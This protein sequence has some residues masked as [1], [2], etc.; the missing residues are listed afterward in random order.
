MENQ[1]ENTC[2]APDQP[3]YEGEI[4][5]LIRS[6]SS[7]TVLKEKLED[8]HENDIADALPKL[9][10][11]ERKKIYRMLSPE[12]LA[13]ILEYAEDS[14]AALYL[15]EM[16]IQRASSVVSEMDSDDAISVLRST[17]K[18]RRADIIDLMDSESK[19]D[20]ALMSSYDKDEIGSRMETNYI[21]IR[22]NLTVKEA[23][24]ELVRQAGENDNI[25]TIFT[26]DKDSEFYGAIDLK[27]LITARQDK[28]LDDLIVTSFPYVYGHEEIDDCIDRLKDY[29]EDSIP[30]LDNDN[31]ILGVITS[32]NLTQ[33]VDEELGE[34]YAKLGGLSAEEDLQEPIKLSIK[35][36][37]PWLILLLFLGMIV[38]SVV[39]MYES[40]V[41]KLTIIMAF[42]S[43]ILDMSGNVGTQSLAVTIRVL[44]DRCITG[45]MKLKLVRKE[46]TTGLANGFL[47]G[48]VAVVGVCIYIMVSHHMPFVSSIAISICIGL[49]LLLA[50]MISSLVGTVIPMFFDKIGVDPAVASG[51]L[52][53]TVTDLVGVVTYYS[54]AWVM[55]VNFLGM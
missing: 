40:V 35:K 27:D 31:K 47:T 53:T 5:S 45:K 8:Y 25:S 22:E 21:V 48:C 20:I 46:M 10:P 9:Q 36:R 18:E 15:S 50:M 49:S 38:S 51:P 37:F 30:V 54:L 29:S 43:M 19:R 24:S 3:N 1:D 17:P 32:Q 55:L 42:Q 23:M 41:A 33:L 12:L 14:E 39:S 11:N 28:S 6:N 34:D 16:D 7:P 52:I 44:M 4:L 2:K 13:E 26:I